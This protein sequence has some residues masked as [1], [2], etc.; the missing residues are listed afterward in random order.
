MIEEEGHYGLDQTHHF[1]S[2]RCSGCKGSIAGCI[3]SADEQRRNWQF[4]RKGSVFFYYEEA[5]SG[6]PLMLRPGGGMNATIS[7]FGNAPSGRST[8]PVEIGLSWESYADDQLGPMDH[9]GIDK[10]FSSSP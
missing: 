4:L 6:F 1:G 10:F 8:G 5:G 9:L 7:F 2:G 3:C